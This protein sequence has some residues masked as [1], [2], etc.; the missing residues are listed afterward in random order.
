MVAKAYKHI[1]QSYTITVSKKVFIIVLKKNTKETNT[2]SLLV[3][4]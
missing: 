3:S 4:H 2:Y 1:R